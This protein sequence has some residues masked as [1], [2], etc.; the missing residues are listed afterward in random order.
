M[1]QAVTLL[2]CTLTFDA[3]TSAANRSTEG[4]KN[5]SRLQGNGWLPIPSSFF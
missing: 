5:K 3:S 2:T 4:M 1:I